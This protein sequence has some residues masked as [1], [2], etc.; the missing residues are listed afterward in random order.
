MCSRVNT[1]STERWRRVSTKGARLA[2]LRPSVKR[3]TALIAYSRGVVAMSELIDGLPKHDELFWP[4][5]RAL[6]QL[7][8]AADNEQLVEKVSELLEIDDDLT[9]IPHKA[10]PQTEIAY[11][12]AWVKSWLKW[13][14]MVDNPRRAAEATEHDLERALEEHLAGRPVSV[15]RTNPIGCN[16]KWDGRDAHWMPPEACDLV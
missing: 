6:R 12:I 13:G 11:R 3:L 10:G 16:V 5:V 9:A 2:L 7:D 15:P 1:V 4:V 8:G 14:G